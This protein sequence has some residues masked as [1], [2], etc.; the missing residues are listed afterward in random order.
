MSDTRTL[1][2]KIAALRSRLDHAHHQVDE[3][4]LTASG[5]L[6]LHSG[7]DEVA[8]D[9]AHD[10]ALDAVLRPL[11]PSGNPSPTRLTAR[12]RLLLERGRDLL[13]RLRELGNTLDHRDEAEPLRQMYAD[14]LAM[15]DTAIRTVALLPDSAAQQLHLCRGLEVT[16]NE[17]HDRLRI[18]HYG[19]DRVR[20]RFEE[21]SA[22]GEML[23]ALHSG[24][25]TDTA[26]LRQLAQQIEAEAEQGLPIYF[27]EASPDYLPGFA[28]AHGLNTARVMARL[29]QADPELH[30]LALDAIVVALVHDVGMLGVDSEVLLKT[31]PWDEEERRGVERH[32]VLGQRAL[33]E[34]FRDSPVLLQAVA[35][36][37]ERLDGTG[38]P[39]GARGDSLHPLTRL[40]AVCDMYAALRSDRPHRPALS[41]RTAL[42]DTLALAE[43]GK[44]DRRCAEYLLRLTFYPVG[45]LV[46]LASGAIA[47]VVATPAARGV[48]L[49]DRPVVAVLTDPEGQPLPVPY[50]RDLTSVQEE[51]IVRTLPVTERQELL[52]RRLAI[53]AA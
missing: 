37:H 24:Q 34:L 27:V 2:A 22:L 28:A 26:L 32:T 49:P 3:A 23:V 46:E 43:R 13:D 41:S 9:A 35:G 33:V 38:Y 31:T 4:R 12:A 16:L 52:R 5:L 30:A 17:V 47:C 40:L 11:H 53:W 36:H 48:V 39:D 10:A 42:A 1:L 6:K 29:I 19:E 7:L 14:T 20:R 44:L 8:R 25:P 45:T 18:L 51:S 15:I 50:Y 21:V